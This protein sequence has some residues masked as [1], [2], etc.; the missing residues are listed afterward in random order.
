MSGMMHAS[1]ILGTFSILLK[2]LYSMCYST[3][4]DFQPGIIACSL[5]R[6]YQC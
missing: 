3:S 6:R 1:K 2:I 5:S 4:T